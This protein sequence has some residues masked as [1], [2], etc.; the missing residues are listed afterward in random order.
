LI[1]R[2]EVFEFI[3]IK[4]TIKRRSLNKKKISILLILNLLIPIYN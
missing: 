2:S 3:Q 4:T 1:F